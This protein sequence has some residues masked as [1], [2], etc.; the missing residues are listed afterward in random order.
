MEKDDAN[1]DIMIMR[2]LVIK[3]I[4]E[5]D[6]PEFLDFIYKLIEYHHKE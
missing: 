5:I 1:S 6:D 2:K 4:E 3:A